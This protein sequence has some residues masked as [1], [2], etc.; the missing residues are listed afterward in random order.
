M[1]IKK[2]LRRIYIFILK[3]DL[4]VHGVMATK[5]GSL[6]ACGLVDKERTTTIVILNCFIYLS[7]REAVAKYRGTCLSSH[8]G[9]GCIYWKRW[10][11][12]RRACS[13]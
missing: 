11:I 7:E 2:S 9:C 8:R 5:V 10:T 3:F 4:N 12:A 1:H 6:L 13:E